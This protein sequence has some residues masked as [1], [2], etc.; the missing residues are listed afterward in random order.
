ML[1]KQDIA[2]IKDILLIFDIINIKNIKIMK[3][4]NKKTELLKGRT[5]YVQIALQ[6]TMMPG[7]EAYTIEVIYEKHSV[8]VAWY[9]IMEKNSKGYT[10][11]YNDCF[12]NTIKTYLKPSEWDIEK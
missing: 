1:N 5:S 12:G 7:L 6:E 3:F 8:N 9:A 4:N 2:Y 10:I 11:T